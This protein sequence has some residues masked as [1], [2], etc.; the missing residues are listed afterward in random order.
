MSGDKSTDPKEPSP[1]GSIGFPKRVDQNLL[2]CEGP[3]C[4]HNCLQILAGRLELELSVKCLL[5]AR[6]GGGARL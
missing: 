4:R 6:H 1:K 3:S 2:D 5:A